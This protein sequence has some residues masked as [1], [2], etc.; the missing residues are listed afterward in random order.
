MFHL[1]A[2]G[3]PVGVKIQHHRLAAGQGLLHGA[4]K[5]LRRGEYP[6]RG[7]LRREH[8]E[9]LVQEGGLH[10][11]ALYGEKHAHGEQEAAQPHGQ[12]LD[13]AVAQVF[14]QQQTAGDNQQQGIE[15][16]GQAIGQEGGGQIHGHGQQDDAEGVFDAVHPCAGLGQD[17]PAER[18][19]QDQRHTGAQRHAV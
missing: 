17:V 6:V 9:R 14:A 7:L 13:L 5:L 11:H 12:R 16:H 4:V 19:H 15:C 8:G 1:L 2:A 10:A 18:A 3:A